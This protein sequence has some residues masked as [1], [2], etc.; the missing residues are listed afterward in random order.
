MTTMKTAARIVAI[1]VVLVTTALASISLAST[2]SNSKLEDAEQ[3]M[4]AR[5]Y[6][7]AIRL[8]ENTQPGDYQSYLK[9]V[10]LFRLGK[11]AETVTEC[12]GLL[13][14]YPESKWKN[15]T[16]FLMARA[17]IA[18]K[19]HKE[20]EAI[21]SKEAGRIFSPARKQKIANVWAFS[22]SCWKPYR[23]GPLPLAEEKGCPTSWI[24][25]ATLE[26]RIS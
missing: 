7:K 17:H 20:A 23:T 21:F 11:N 10:A 8:L 1:C 26:P 13:K 25:W 3:A 22:S 16:S 9:A 18:Q 12:E 5:Q 15:K 14:T 4:Q 19:N 6:D 2:S 24:S